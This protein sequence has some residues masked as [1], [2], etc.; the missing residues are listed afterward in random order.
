M[1]DELYY[2]EMEADR[3]EA[4]RAYFAARP[5]ADAMIPRKFF[6]AGF[7]RAYRLLWKE[8]P[9][10]QPVPPVPIGSAT[11]APGGE[12]K[13]RT[14]RWTAKPGWSAPACQATQQLEWRESTAAAFKFCPHCG[15]KIIPE[16]T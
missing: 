6:C 15:G 3:N 10:A 5:H 9:P 11:A 2:A 16:S 12:S 1:T 13:E 4:E 7:E 14:C 8:S